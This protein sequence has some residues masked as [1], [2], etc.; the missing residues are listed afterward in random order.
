MDQQVTVKQDEI[1][2]IADRVES[3]VNYL[4]KTVNGEEPDDTHP[5][6]FEILFQATW[7]MDVLS[8]KAL[9]DEGTLA[10]QDHPW[11]LPY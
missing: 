2:N 6:V 9:I 7:S 1:K 8:S 3:A 4:G 5:D 11:N 10:G